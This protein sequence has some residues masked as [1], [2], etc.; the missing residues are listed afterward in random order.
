MPKKTEISVSYWGGFSEPA[1]SMEDAVKKLQEFSHTGEIR[2]MKERGY[3]TA[4]EEYRNTGPEGPGWYFVGRIT[5]TKTD[6][7]RKEQ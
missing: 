4:F 2:K 7:C 5:E 1:D 3:E 6:T